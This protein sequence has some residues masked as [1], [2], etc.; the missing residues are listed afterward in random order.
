MFQRLDGYSGNWN[1]RNNTP[2]PQHYYTDE[3]S[4]AKGKISQEW[5]FP[6]S[7]T[8]SHRIEVRSEESG[9]FQG[10]FHESDSVTDLS[11]RQSSDA[12]IDHDSLDIPTDE[13]EANEIDCGAVCFTVAAPLGL[14]AQVA[15]SLPLWFHGDASTSSIAVSRWTD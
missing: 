14:A 5:N 13:D 7:I 15:R 6:S 3:R 10:N 1:T 4:S 8:Y 2:M 11:R 9:F 12:R